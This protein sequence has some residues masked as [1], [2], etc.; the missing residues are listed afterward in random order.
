MCEGV[1]PALLA[2]STWVRRRCSR[3]VARTSARHRAY[4]VSSYRGTGGG[5]ASA[6]STRE[7][8]GR[9]LGHGP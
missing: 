6:S 8:T 4:S 5:T 3:V 7:L 9:A 1:V 2:S